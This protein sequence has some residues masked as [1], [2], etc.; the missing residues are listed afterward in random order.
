MTRRWR[1]LAPVFL[2]CLAL[3]ATAPGVAARSVSYPTQ[4]L[5][6]RG[7]EVRAIQAIL[8]DH[9]YGLAYDGV[10]GTTTRDAV[11]S[12]QFGHG[13]TVTGIVNDVT[14][15]S[16]LTP[17]G[18]GSVGVAVRVLQREL[19]VKNHAGLTMN[20][21][22]GATTKAA[23]VAFQKH[24]ALTVTGSA[25]RSTWRWL[26][27]HFEYPKFNTTSLC[28]YSVGNGL[29]NWGTAASIGQLQA[30]AAAFAALG[31]GRISVGDVSLEHGGDIAGHVMHEVGL[32][33]DI[34]P[35][36]DDEGQC[37]ARTNWKVASYDR[38]ATRALLKTIRATAGG[39]VKVIYFNDPVL[40]GEGLVRAYPGHDDHLHIRYC[41]AA[42]PDPRYTC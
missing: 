13:L 39:H 12:F 35:I 34:R 25:N 23:V 3:A 8:I 14:W 24:M 11:R 37:R 16:L 21:I 19:N 28:D 22:Y 30:T 42:H 40:I 6:D 31:H 36:R 38:S 33:V 18:P 9:G 41:E 27:W 15:N 20:G 29:A 5:G 1:L 32:D 4:S 10:F 17:V 7:S 26:L 2:A